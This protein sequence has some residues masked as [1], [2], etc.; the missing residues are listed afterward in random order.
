MPRK[1]DI[2]QADMAASNAIFWDGYRWDGSEQLMVQSRQWVTKLPQQNRVDWVSSSSLATV[3]M[4]AQGISAVALLVQAR[5]ND[6]RAPAWGITDIFNML[7]GL[8]FARL[9]ASLWLS[10]EYGSEAIKRQ[11]VARD[12]QLSQVSAFWKNSTAMSGYRIL[13]PDAGPNP[14]HE[15]Q[16]P[17]VI[18]RLKPNSS[19]GARLWTILGIVATTSCRGVGIYST[20]AGLGPRPFVIIT[21]LSSLCVCM[22][23]FVLTLCAALIF[24]FY[25]LKGQAGNTVLP[26]MNTM[27][28]KWLN[29]VMIVLACLMFTTSA[30]EATILPNGTVTTYPIP[31]P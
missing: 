10:D 6:W 25:I 21:Q 9:P 29:I 27:W 22:Y 23:Y 30:L 20:V 4:T 12:V 31:P 18:S 14:F 28:Y 16:V 5:E 11:S 24:I 2:H 26:C 15:F 8:S 13:T 7:A 3:A 17:I 19:F 1:V